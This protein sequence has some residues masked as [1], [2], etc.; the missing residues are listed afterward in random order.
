MHIAR[1]AVAA[2]LQGSLPPLNIMYVLG[3][4][5]VL[6]E[7][8]I[9]NEIRAMRAQGHRIVPLALRPF[10]GA[11]QPEDEAFKAE[12]IHLA[13]IPAARALLSA[14]ANPAGMRSALQFATRQTGIPPRSLMLAGARVALAAIQSGCTHL[15]AHFALPG[16]ATAIVAAR[17]AGITCSFTSH[18]Y[19]VYGTPA[20]L[21]AKLEA[22]DVAIAV[23]EDMKA[24]FLRMVPSARVELVYCGV[25]PARF[26]PS[27]EE[28]SNGRLLAIGRLVEQ[29]GYDVLLDALALMPREERPVIDVVGG[30]ELAGELTEQAERLG[31]ADSLNFLGA[32]PGTWIVAEGPK[33]AGFIAPYVIC[34]NGDRD[35][36]P[37]VVREAMAMGL[38]V[39]VSS[40]MG[41]KEFVPPT[42]GRQ[43]PQRDPAALAEA[44]RWLNTLSPRD[45]KWMG[46]AG[47]AR[48]QALYT[49]E[50]E[51]AGLAA[52]IRSVARS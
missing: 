33:Y 43:F 45:R 1:D 9:S 36:G 47:R 37:M 13:S 12:T 15:H 24:D 17:L 44:L 19:D 18:G 14:A 20:D 48:V 6:S 30:G 35:T 50:A 16:A 38:P 29:K 3:A 34:K 2:P 4:F 5:P 8:F 10:D 40:V 22:V 7:T 21:E 42:C 25:D 39:A 46:A 49:L 11:C 27:R 31:V 41:M 52:A 26:V 32:R 51:A 28:T 23:C